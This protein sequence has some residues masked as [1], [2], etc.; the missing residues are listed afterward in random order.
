MLKLAF[1]NIFRNKK[2]TSL[3]LLSVFFAAMVVGLAQ[4]WANG[5]INTMISNMTKYQTGDI[6]ITDEN[7][8]KRE[9][10][11]PVDNLIPDSARLQSDLKKLDG[12]KSVEERMRFAILLGKGEKS[13]STIGYGLDLNESVLKVKDKLSGENKV[14]KPG[15][16]Y[17]GYRLAEKLDIKE[18]DEILIAVQSSEGG[19][20]GLK[21]RVNGLV[22]MNVSVLDKKAFFMSIETASDL[23]KI[24]DASTEI[25]VFLKDRKTVNTMVDT[26]SKILPD[27]VKA[28]SYITQLGELYVTLDAGK[29]FYVFIEIM[30][31][32]L[33]SFVII[34]TLMMA[35]YERM[36]EIGTLKS[37]GFTNRQLFWNFTLEGSIIGAIGG[38]I[39]AFS[40]YLIIVL[41][42]VTGI[43]LETM[44]SGMDAPLEYIVYP[45]LSIIQPFIAAAVCIVIPAIASMFP[46]RLINK[47]MPA[48]ALRK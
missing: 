11:L 44:F 26:V 22:K 30:I 32:L 46:S 5:I 10:F 27:G 36:R 1:K 15:G 14:I 4:G 18:G 9:K 45:E 31:M 23:L 16:V 19:L 33:G 41:L 47:I 37:I 3:T 12:V 48:E 13:E 2:R 24:N 43:N 25:Y 17:M 21:L 6:R 38:T 29:V 40:G 28:E 34:N 39:G 42:S 7:F 20:N 8:L 35:I